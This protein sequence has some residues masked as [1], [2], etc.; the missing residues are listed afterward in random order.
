MKIVYSITEM[1]KISRNIKQKAKTIGFVPTMGYLHYGHL[2]LMT[3]SVKECDVTVVSI[4]VNP[5]QFGPKEDFKKYPRDVKKDI[6][7]CKQQGVDY[8]FIPNDEQIYPK[9]YATQVKVSGITDSLCGKSRP[10]HFKGV[11]TIVN[12]LFNL[13]MPDIAYFG[14]KDAQQALVIKM[15]VK[16]LHM[17]LKIKVLP[18][19][20]ESDGLAMSSRNSYLNDAQRR[21]AVLL[22]ESLKKAKQLIA[23]KQRKSARII[24]E[25]KRLL[26]QSEFA[27]IDYINI[28][29]ADNLNEVKQL[30]L[31]MKILIILAVD[32]GKVRL[33]DNI[34][35]RVG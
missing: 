5:M 33:I 25:M 12:K 27:I 31:N 10:G 17:S 8:V 18:T 4:Y 26:S 13:V 16:D 24:F 30:K 28:V 23:Q 1:H 6:K 11:T 35:V 9:G 2:S 32:V 34:I 29:D 22:F 7:L 21:D 20:R 3:K 14:Q 19:I 15:M